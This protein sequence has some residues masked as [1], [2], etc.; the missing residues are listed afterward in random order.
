MPHLL[1]FIYNYL[2]L[3][4]FTCLPWLI[5]HVYLVWPLFAPFYPNF[6]LCLL[7]FTRLLEFTC[8]LVF[9]YVYHCLFLHVYL[10]LPTF[11]GVYLLW[12]LFTYVY[13][14]LLVFT[15]GCGPLFSRVYLYL[16]V[17]CLPM[18]AHVHSC[19]HMFT[20]LYLCLP[21]I[22]TFYSCLNKFNRVYLLITTVYSCFP[23]FCNVYL[24][25]F[26]SVCPCLLVFT[27]V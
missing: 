3:L 13:P 25:L 8:L 17:S 12:L 15:Y 19:L 21:V 20:F 4:V 22:T 6:L 18:F 24:S 14:C 9:F 7:I 2:C 10:C 26:T 27:Y 11:T 1:V 5:V 23:N 16:H